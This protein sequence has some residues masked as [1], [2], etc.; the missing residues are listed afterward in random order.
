MRVL[1]T[2]SAGQ[3]GRSLIETLSPFSDV[4]ATTRRELDLTDPGGI[5][6]VVGDTRPD[7]IVNAAAYTRVDDAE[8]ERDLARRVNAEAPGLLGSAAARTGSA[9]LH[10]STDYVF[11]GKNPEPYSEDDEPG[12]LNVYG[13]TKLAGERAL[14]GAGAPHLILRLSWLYSARG[15]NFFNTILREAQERERLDVVEDQIG[16]PTSTDAVARATAAILGR[17]EISPSD[18]FSEKGGLYHFS[19]DGSTSWKGF[20]EAIVR[21]ARSA[22]LLVRTT[23]IRGI[24]GREYPSTA[25]RPDNSRLDTTLI[26]HAFGLPLTDWKSALAEVFESLS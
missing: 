16:A 8:T 23:E 4:V 25:R 15:K 26:R 21:G 18:V 5:D 11:D 9:V 17:G 10:F 1:V 22:G 19:C 2:G 7:L 13:E 20:A 3:L 6:E 14:G 24:P 12:P